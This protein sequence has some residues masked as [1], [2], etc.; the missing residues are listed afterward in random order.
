MR[1]C[2]MLL[3]MV[4]IGQHLA[5]I[6]RIKAAPIEPIYRRRQSR[7][8]RSVGLWV[9]LGNGHVGGVVELGSITPQE[10]SY[11][12]Q[13]HGTVRL[14][15]I[16]AANVRAAVYAAARSASMILA[17]ERSGRYQSV[18]IAVEPVFTAIVSMQTTGSPIVEPIPIV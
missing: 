6:T 10:F 7:W 2:R 15:P 12:L 5:P 3:S 14:R 17:G 13:R 16:D 9:W 4:D 11:G 8:W 1:P 18:K